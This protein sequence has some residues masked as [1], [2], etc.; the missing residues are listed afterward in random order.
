MIY[1]KMFV[2]GVSR[3]NI[4]YRSISSKHNTLPQCPASTMLAQHHIDIVAMYCV[5]W[6][7]AEIQQKDLCRAQPTDSIS[8]LHK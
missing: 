5:S 2:F 6:N 8:L 1:L 7:T 3:L 4:Y